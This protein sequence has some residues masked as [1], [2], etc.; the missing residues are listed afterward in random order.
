LLS[1]SPVWT[2]AFVSRPYLQHSFTLQGR[3]PIAPNDNVS[4]RV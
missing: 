1:D 3:F 2:T 4:T